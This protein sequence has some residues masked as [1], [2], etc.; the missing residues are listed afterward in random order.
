MSILSKIPILI[1]AIHGYAIKW[2]W[3][4]FGI[5]N[6]E[7]LVRRTDGQPE[8]VVSL[9]SYGRRVQTGVVYYCLVSIL[10]QTE[11]PNRLI[12]TLTD[13]EEVIPEKLKNLEMYGV[14]IQ[15]S[16]DIRSYKKLIPILRQCPDDIIVTI[17]DD[18]IYNSRLLEI[19]MNNYEHN[20]TAIHSM[21]SS[22]PV[23]RNGEVA[24]YKEWPL[25][26]DGE[27]GLHVFSIGV[28][29]VLYPPHCLHSDVFDKETFMKLCPMADDI[30]FWLQAVRNGTRHQNI[31]NNGVVNY[32]F[33]ALYQYLHK[34][35]ALTHSN[36]FENANDKQLAAL[37]EHYGMKKDI[38]RILS[39]QE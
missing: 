9:T 28:N 34:G 2:R 38:L 25:A 11:R 22:R 31:I 1:N 30:W 8:L 12:L 10:K 29:S 32:S 27:T 23:L 3:D 39:N 21:N 13:K 24:T 6:I 35:S 14:E 36:R 19:L 33:D 17:D 37:I 20:K 5:G 18:V 16:E 7:P 4:V 26:E 15:Y